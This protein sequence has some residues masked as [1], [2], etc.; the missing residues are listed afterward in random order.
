MFGW[1]QSTVEQRHVAGTRGAVTA[2]RYG[3]E[4][5]PGRAAS[6]HDERVA[7]GRGGTGRTREAAPVS[8]RGPRRVPGW[9]F[10]TFLVN[11]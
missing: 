8:A 5:G 4:V 7:A 6:E 3:D 9:W 2:A 11:Q 10:G 1:F